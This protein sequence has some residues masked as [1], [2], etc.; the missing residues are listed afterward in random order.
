MLQN[1]T[2]KSQHGC[3]WFYF[4]K[5]MPCSLC[6]EGMDSAVKT[7]LEWTPDLSH[8][9]DMPWSKNISEPQVP[10]RWNGEG[11]ISRRE[12][13]LR[14]CAESAA[15]SEALA[16]GMFHSILSGCGRSGSPERRGSPR[17]PPLPRPLVVCRTKAEH[18]KKNP[19]NVPQALQSFS[20]WPPSS[21]P[22][23]VLIKVKKCIISLI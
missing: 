9:N 14:Q 18:F 6:V 2:W 4:F 19:S 7:F 13:T 17:I 22:L 1:R 5:H 3:G 15:S 20:G 16:V 11:D 23:L 12:E 8:T 10:Y 21:G